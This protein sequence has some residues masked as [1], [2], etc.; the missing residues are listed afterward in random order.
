MAMRRIAVGKFLLLSMIIAFIAACD[1]ETEAPG[2]PEVEDEIEVMHFDIDDGEE[3]GLESLGDERRLVGLIDETGTQ[4]DYVA[5]ELLFIGDEGLEEFLERWDG[6]LV[7]SSD[8]GEID[9]ELPVVHQVVVDATLGDSA[10]LP[11]LFEQYD[12]LMA[13]EFVAT[14]EEALGLLAI[15]MKEKVVHGNEVTINPYFPAQGS[16][17]AYIDQ[18]LQAAPAANSNADGLVNGAYDPNPKNWQHF[19][20]GSTQDVGVTDAWYALA[21]AGKTDPTVSDRVHMLILDGGFLD[22]DL[23]P[24]SHSA[25]FGMS[26]VGNCGSGNPCPWHGI[27][28]AQVAV[29]NPHS[30]TGTIGTGGPVASA[31][32]VGVPGDLMEVLKW[33][34]FGPPEFVA[35]N[36]QIVN[37]S[38]GLNVHWTI[39]TAMG[40]TNLL[41]GI[42]LAYRAAGVLSISA[43]GNDGRFLHEQTCPR[44][45]F[46]A[47]WERHKYLP[48]QA[49]GVVCVGGLDDDSLS[50]HPG[51]N[52]GHDVDLW[53]SFRQF[54]TLDGSQD[55]PN[56]DLDEIFAGVGTSFSAPYVAGVAALVMAADPSLSPRAVR[57][58]LID[59]AR[60]GEGRA[61]KVIQAREAVHEA[62]GGAPFRMD[63]MSP[64]DGAVFERGRGILPSVSF[65]AGDFPSTLTWRFDGEVIGHGTSAVVDPEMTRQLEPGTYEISITAEAGPYELTRTRHV[66]FVRSPPSISLNAPTDG[67]VYY[68]S[69]TIPL[70]ATST[71]AESSDGTLDDSQV[72]WTVQ[73]TGSQIAT[74]HLEYVSG[75][76]L[77][78]GTWTL[79]VTGSDG[80]SD[81]VDE[82]TISVEEDPEV[83]P[84]D[85][86]IIS[87]EDDDFYNHSIHCCGSIDG[88]ETGWEVDFNGAAFHDGTELSGDALVWRTTV[89]KKLDGNPTTRVLGTGTSFTA[90]LYDDSTGAD[91][92]TH[93]IELTATSPEGVSR[94]VDISVYFPGIIQ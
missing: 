56:T 40:L 28:V 89:D 18:T 27:A 82:V 70:F 32:M 13:G 26:N 91:W 86:I 47:C 79:E 64:A 14:D 39:A 78:V 68:E 94:T 58:L 72:V 31:S 33:L 30:G 37:M 80:V 55:T 65:L 75:S 35:G 3:P 67:E 90:M 48:C 63:F 53:A 43:A 25:M 12:E 81:A 29:G 8:L 59:T 93:L 66:E 34:A 19:N 5:N 15:A 73:E 71:H 50:R 17:F 62:L 10:A 45:A 21:L 88:Y 9:A 57:D 54:Q 84:P 42:F 46:G 77:G 85:V 16:E 38:F 69:S 1:S 49:S 44:L 83:V 6:T 7:E 41:S 2:E 87:P 60:D 61:G 23:T 76:V 11:E 22:L 24:G 4:I 52:Y 36:P 20:S 51:S 92:N 74:G